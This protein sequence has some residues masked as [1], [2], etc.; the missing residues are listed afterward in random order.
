MTP[1]LRIL[2]SPIGPV[3][4]I[5]DITRQIG[6]SRSGATRVI[7]R[8]AGSFV[9]LTATVST[10]TRAGTR[11]TKCLTQKGIEEFIRFLAPDPVLYP[12]LAERVRQFKA[13]AFGEAA[14]SAPALPPAQPDEIVTA[15]MVY[16][17]RADTLINRWGYK[18]EVARSLC[19]A[20]AVEKYP[21]LVSIRGPATADSTVLELPEKTGDTPID[22]ELPKADPDFERYFPLSKIAEMCKCDEDVARRILE[23][24]GIIGFANR[25]TTLSTRSS[26]EDFGKVFTCYPYFPHRMTPRGHIRYNSDKCCHLI[27]EKLFGIQA[28]LS[29]FQ[30]APVKVG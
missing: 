4:P 13:R 3:I 14:Q 30:R 27:R 22:T 5:V 1:G 23:D 16:A 6:Y 7:E 9:G 20:A 29:E 25:H 24:E 10:K 21:D 26:L 12:D 2:E 8:H 18:P 15:L 28:P 19:M 11:P 17:D